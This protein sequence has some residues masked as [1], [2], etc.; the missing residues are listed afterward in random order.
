MLNQEFNM[1]NN[2]ESARATADNTS[3]LTILIPTLPF[4]DRNLGHEELQ[5]PATR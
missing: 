1:I 3:K 4:P 2:E 5:T